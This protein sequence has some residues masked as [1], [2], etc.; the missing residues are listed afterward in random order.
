MRKRKLDA[1]DM[2]HLRRTSTSKFTPSFHLA[3][4]ES[5]RSRKDRGEPSDRGCIHGNKRVNH[6]RLARRQRPSPFGTYPDL[7][8][9]C[10]RRARTGFAGVEGAIPATSSSSLGRSLSAFAVPF[11]GSTFKIPSSLDGI[12]SLAVPF[13]GSAFGTS[14]LGNVVPLVGGLVLSTDAATVEFCDGSDS[15]AC[16]MS[17][18]S[19]VPGVTELVVGLVLGLMVKSA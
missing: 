7:Q 14:S 1:L 8:R 2:A 18:F 9:F 16:V 19:V 3:R 15:E 11:D 6:G 13:D 12:V 5:G 4:S 10:D 17:F